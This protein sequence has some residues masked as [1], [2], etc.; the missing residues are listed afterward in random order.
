[1][2]INAVLPGVAARS[3]LVGA[4]LTEESL[5]AVRT[6]AFGQSRA[7]LSEVEDVV[8]ASLVSAEARGAVARQLAGL[9]SGDT[10]PAGKQFVCRQLAI[11]GTA[12]QVPALAP[13]LADP[14]TAD[15]ARYAL[16]PIPGPEVDAALIEALGSAPDA[17]KAGIANSLGARRCAAAV[18]KL[19]ELTGHSDPVIAECA[20][21]A[22]AKIGP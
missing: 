8:R 11:V 13:L 7:P 6:Y 17:A 1:M 21:A 16:E 19:K 15:M 10:T 5:K 18:P 14:A 4:A 3:A 12:E 20:Q 9:L 2:N 22:L